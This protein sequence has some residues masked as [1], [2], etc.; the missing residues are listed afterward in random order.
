MGLTTWPCRAV[1][2]RCLQKHQ[3]PAAVTTFHTPGGDGPSRL[4]PP[5][6]GGAGSSFCVLGLS[7]GPGGND[8]KKSKL[9]KN[10]KTCITNTLKLFIC[11]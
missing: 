9:P 6:G 10:T 5:W 7:E 3:A 4:C 2:S 11:T 8:F 1:G